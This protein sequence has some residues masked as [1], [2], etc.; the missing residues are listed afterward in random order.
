MDGAVMA[1]IAVVPVVMM[2]VVVMT[3]IMA[4]A[5]S[6]SDGDAR[7]RINVNRGS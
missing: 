6:K 1:V 2:A 3:P 7:D 4:K 5:E